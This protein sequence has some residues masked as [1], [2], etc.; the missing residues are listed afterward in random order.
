M[1]NGWLC[2]S[3][4]LHLLRESGTLVGLLDLLDE[5]K[6][7]PGEAATLAALVLG[8]DE[9]PDWQAEPKAFEVAL[10]AK[11]SAAPRTFD[12]RR[13]RLSPQ[14]DASRCLRAIHG[15]GLLG[16]GIFGLALCAL[17]AAGLL[18]AALDDGAA[19]EVGYASSHLT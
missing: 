4:A 2:Y 10:R 18:S 9:L 1:G 8:A 6:L 16:C 13:R 19:A 11:A 12:A 7:R 5:R 15:H 3:P 17:V 14:V